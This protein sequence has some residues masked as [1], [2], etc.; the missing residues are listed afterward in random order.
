MKSVYIDT[1]VILRR[2][3]AQPGALKEWG[4]WDEV[5]TSE[6]TRVEFFRTLDRMRLAGGLAD[7][8]YAALAAEFAAAWAQ[9]IRVPVSPDVLARASQAFPTTLGALDALHLASLLLVETVL[10]RRVT[11]LTH[12]RQLSL[13]ARSMGVACAGV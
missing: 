3:L 4:A 7:E 11:L 6:I 13:A 1:S 9:S 10:G 12:D 2:L 8:G 5:V